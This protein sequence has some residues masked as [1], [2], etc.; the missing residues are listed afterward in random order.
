MLDRRTLLTAAAAGA[1]APLLVGGTAAAAPT[2]GKVLAKN[3]QV[4]WG[5]AFLPS[6]DALVGERPNGQVHRVRKGGGR[7][8]VGR[9]SAVRDRGEGGLLGI[10][11]APT[12]ADDSWVYFYFTSG[13]D[14]RIVRKRLRGGELGRTQVVLDGIPAASNHNGGRLAFG[15]DGMLYAS[16]GDAGDTSRAQDK[17][18][19]GGKILRLRP[20]GSV[21]DDNPFGSRVWSYGHRN[22]Q[23]LAWDGAGRLWAT[24]L[25]Q[26]T[27]DEL[28]RIRPGRNYGWP[29][30][31]GGD[32][33]GPYADPF[34]T[35]STEDCSPSGL[36]IARGRAWVGALR[37]QSLWSVRLS[38]PRAR[39][40]AR[41]FRGDFGRIRTVQKAPDGSLWITTSNRDGRGEPSGT[42][43]RV[44]RVAP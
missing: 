14:N 16:T 42:D 20:N 39:R 6:G 5:V 38:G 17:G 35:W 34:V 2:A 31:E 41:H 11:V 15:P 28:N 21:P 43:D 23:G 4:P 40:K 22:V 12:F 27:R 13:D 36:A 1:T 30:V 18:S 8:L 7:S 33:D 24:E 3:L 29:E 25:G 44:V 10:A 19:L 9:L 26:N 32:G 37:G